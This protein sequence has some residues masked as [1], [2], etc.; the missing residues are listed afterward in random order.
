MIDLSTISELTS[1]ADARALIDSVPPELEKEA[2]A[3]AINFAA[4]LGEFSTFFTG[5]ISKALL[6]ELES[7]GYT[8]GP[9]PYSADADSDNPTVWVIMWAEEQDTP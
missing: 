2:V 1:A 4:N 9:V 7:Q 5:Y 3:R 8:V 6:K